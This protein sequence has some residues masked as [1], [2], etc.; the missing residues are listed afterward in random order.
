VLDGQLADHSNLPRFFNPGII[1]AADL[2]FG[3]RA[4]DLVP[5]RSARNWR[6]RPIMLIHGG[7]D[8]IVP[9]RQ[10]DLIAAQAGPQCLTVVLPGVE[11]VQAYHSDPAGYVTAVDAFFDRNLAR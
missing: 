4:R 3:V 2:A 11:H 9:A 10:A 7:D 1:T 8:S 6:D 5:I